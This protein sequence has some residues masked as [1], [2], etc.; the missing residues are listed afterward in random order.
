MGYVIS[1]IGRNLLVF[2]ASLLPGRIYGG[3]DWLGLL[4]VG[5]LAWIHQGWWF[6]CYFGS[7]TLIGYSSLSGHV[8]KAIISIFWEN[9]S[10]HVLLGYRRYDI[11]EISM[12][13]GQEKY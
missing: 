13:N 12:E 10:T 2:E 5:E 11:P 8:Q 4:F 3:K 7:E 1:S 6:L 9:A